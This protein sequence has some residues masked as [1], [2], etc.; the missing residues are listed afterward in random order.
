VTRKAS[1]TSP[2][3]RTQSC[4][5]SAFAS[6]LATAAHLTWTI[7]GPIMTAPASKATSVHCC[8]QVSLRRSAQ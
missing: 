2:A 8:P 7:C 4:D 5:E 6:P 3:A 1:I